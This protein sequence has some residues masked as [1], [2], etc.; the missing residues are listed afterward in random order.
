MPEHAGMLSRT[1]HDVDI[2]FL[3]VHTA[4]GQ[5]ASRTLIINKGSR[6]LRP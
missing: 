3:D 5:R 6:T 2:L 1:L 4:E